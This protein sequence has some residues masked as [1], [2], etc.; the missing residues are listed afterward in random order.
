MRITPGIASVD[1]SKELPN[2]VEG[3]LA[4]RP[5]LLLLLLVG[6]RVVVT[7]LL[8]LLLDEVEDVKR[9][10]VL[11]LRY[12]TSFAAPRI[13]SRAAVSNSTVLVPGARIVSGLRDADGE[14]DVVEPGLVL[15]GEED[16][17]RLAFVVNISEESPLGEFCGKRGVVKLE[18]SLGGGCGH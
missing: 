5:W 2:K 12:S 3:L 4:K 1:E 13:E 9:S 14:D 16:I 15:R 11:T 17:T 6:V 10:K 18:S 7:V 8:V